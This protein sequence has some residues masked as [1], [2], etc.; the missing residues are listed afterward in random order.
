VCSAGHES[1]LSSYVEPKKSYA[2]QGGV[3]RAHR[4]SWLH[5]CST[6]QGEGQGA[7]LEHRG[8]QIDHLPENSPEQK[9]P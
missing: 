9:S 4:G 6:L 1:T 2:W 8:D 5:R 7:A 3:A